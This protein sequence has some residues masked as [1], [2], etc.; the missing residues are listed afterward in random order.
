MGPNEIAARG[1]T[2]VVDERSELLG[3]V[4]WRGIFTMDEIATKVSIFL[5]E[6]DRLHHHSLHEAVLNRAK[7]YGVIGATVWRGI[8]GFGKS[9]RV[10][11]SR[12]PDANTGLPLVVE[13]IDSPTRMEDFLITISDLT[14]GLL[15]TKEE[16]RVTRTQTPANQ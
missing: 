6:D 15:V 9:G 2:N 16:V 11:T 3:P 14:N 10:R 4:A 7:D 5:S 1:D 13:L 8:E 12:F